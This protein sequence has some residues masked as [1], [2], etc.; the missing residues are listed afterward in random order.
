MTRAI[1]LAEGIIGIIGIILAWNGH[2][3]E[4]VAVAGLMA[5]TLDKLRKP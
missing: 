1:W 5:A 3:T 2:I 4:A